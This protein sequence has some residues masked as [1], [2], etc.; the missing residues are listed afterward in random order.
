MDLLKEESK[1]RCLKIHAGIVRQH[2]PDLSI[3]RENKESNVL[4]E[5]RQRVINCTK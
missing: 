5:A 2:F 4:L 3:Y 1:Q